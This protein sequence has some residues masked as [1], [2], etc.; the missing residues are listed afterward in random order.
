MLVLQKRNYPR[1]YRYII[2]KTSIEAK[3]DLCPSTATH[4]VRSAHLTSR[5]GKI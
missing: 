3:P 4:I 2:L 1:D 5:A